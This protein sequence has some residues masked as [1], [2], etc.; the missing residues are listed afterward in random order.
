MHRLRKAF[1][2]NERYARNIAV[3]Y[4]VVLIFIILTTTSSR[5]IEMENQNYISIMTADKIILDNSKTIDNV[6]LPYDIENDLAKT[7]YV[8]ISIPKN[9]YKIAALSFI[10]SQSNVTI[11]HNKEPIYNHIYLAKPNVENSGSGRVFCPLFNIKQGDKIRI[12]LDKIND[13]EFNSV[14]KIYL[15]NAVMTEHDYI[16]RNKLI[17]GI[18]MGLFMSGVLLL[19]AAVVYTSF[20]ASI[21]SLIYLSSFIISSSGWALS[22]SKMMQI[23]TSN[24]EMMYSIEYMCLYAIPVS[25]WGFLDSNWKRRHK[26]GKIGFLISY[27][28]FVGALTVKAFGIYDFYESVVIFQWSS[29]LSGG[30]LT[31]IIFKKVYGNSKSLKLFYFSALTVIIVGVYE[32]FLFYKFPTYDS[33]ENKIIYA[34]AFMVIVMLANYV[35]SSRSFLEKLLEDKVYRELAYKDALTGLGNRAKFERDILELETKIKFKKLIF[36]VAD[37][38]YLKNI[39]DTMGHVV[40]DLAIKTIGESIKAVFENIGGIYRVGGDEFCIIVKDKDTEYVKLMLE[41]VDEI[42]LCTELG[43]PISISYGFEQYDLNKH[44][45]LMKLYKSADDRMYETKSF[46][47]KMADI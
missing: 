3:I 40:G 19:I 5:T 13:A 26:I 16:P 25:L 43:F 18:T 2:N 6:K 17:F 38:N 10:A 29:I 46:Y 30:I 9:P 36:I 14:D 15:Q 7:V 11:Y 24:W 33:L 12:E 31:Y 37:V 41:E 45:S 32:I 20:G 22:S 8:D 27:I 44:D 21:K 34:L 47:R 35:S 42:L 23:F 28:F 1:E 39:N 4:A